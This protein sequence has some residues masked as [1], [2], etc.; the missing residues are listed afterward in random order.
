MGCYYGYNRVSTKEQHLDRGSQAIRSFCENAGYPLEKI[1]EDKQTGRNFDRPRYIVL[2]EDVLRE[3]DTLIV[4]EYDRLGRA[5]ETKRELEYFKDKHIR[6]IFLDIPTTYMDFSGLPDEMSKMILECINGM[7]IS[8]YDLQAR[9]EIERKA[10]RQREGIQAMK[11]RGEWERYGRKRI[12]SKD[13][14]AIQYQRVVDNEIGSLQL[15]REL[16]MSHNTYFRYVREFKAE[17]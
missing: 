11:D 17:N 8:F 15:M 16:G 1:Y 14:F 10:K 3:G 12:M 9:T 6:I 2:K 7:L 5:D 4:P 13:D